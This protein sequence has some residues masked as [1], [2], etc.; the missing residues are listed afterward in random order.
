MYGNTALL[1]KAHRALNM[2]ERRDLKINKFF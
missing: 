2:Y 1:K